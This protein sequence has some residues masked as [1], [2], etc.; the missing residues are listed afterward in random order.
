MAKQNNNN[1]WYTDDIN[2]LNSKS[3]ENEITRIYPPEI[4]CNRENSNENSGHFLELDIFIEN[5]KFETKL[6]DKRREF[7]FEI[8]KYP[9]V[10]SNIPNRI[11]YN[12]FVSQILRYARVCS[13]FQDFQTESRILITKFSYK[14]C[15]I[16]QLKSKTYSC[17]NSH[18]P[19][20][21]KFNMRV[22][23]I[24]EILFPL[25]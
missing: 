12:V 4:V 17:I 14:G 24:L 6:F 1:F 5:G 8:V 21:S 13:N 19:D 10:Q 3:L 20:F 7:D 18:I 2:I 25:M 15:K 9:D 23:D 11:L 22:N 16:D